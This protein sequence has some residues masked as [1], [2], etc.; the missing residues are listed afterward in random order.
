MKTSV[1]IY[2]GSFDPVTNGHLDLI[3][4]GEKGGPSWLPNPT[5]TSA[6]WSFNTF[7]L[8]DAKTH[9]VTPMPHLG[10][11]QPYYTSDGLWGFWMRAPGGP[12]RRRRGSA[13]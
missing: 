3:E 6:C 11:C 5:L 1:A 7:S 12:R 2:P 10:G 4:R 9:K 13:A 8:L